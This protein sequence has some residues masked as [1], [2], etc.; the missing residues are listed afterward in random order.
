[1]FDTDFETA[2]RKNQKV[3]VSKKMHPDTE[4]FEKNF[5]E[6]GL[7]YAIEKSSF[8]SVNAKRG[9]YNKMPGFIRPLGR[10]IYYTLVKL[11]KRLK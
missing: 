11:K 6:G 2:V 9:I 3:I 1:M 4:E 10:K 5:K 8:K 7:M